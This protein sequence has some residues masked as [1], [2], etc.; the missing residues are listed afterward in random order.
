[1]AKSIIICFFLT[2]VL[3]AFA[4]TRVNDKFPYINKNGDLI[5]QP[6]DSS[7]KLKSLNIDFM[8]RGYFYAYSTPKNSEDDDGGGWAI[9]SNKPQKILKADFPANIL[10]IIIDTNQ[11]DT[12]AKQYV[13]YRI[14]VSNRT[15][16][17]T[18][19]NAQDSRLYMKMQAQNEK[20]EW[21]DIEYLPRSWC[22]NSY[23]KLELEP[24]AY[25]KFIIPKYHGKLQTKLRAELMYID[26]GNPE[27]QKFI[28]SNIISGSINPG[29]F[30]NKET[31][32]PGGLMDPYND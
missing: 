20:G 31:Y 7:K 12:F 24:N 30:R 6:I 17:T 23:H 15:G 29:Q 19:F 8:N 11:I 4:Q 28:Y 26:K 22:G 32:Q 18:K 13:G 2:I 3:L 25:W 21:K 14:F 9:S 16:D 10:S 5:W 27:N 1:M